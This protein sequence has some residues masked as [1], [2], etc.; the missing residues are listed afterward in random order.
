M[1]RER[2]CVRFLGS[3]RAVSPLIATV[4]LIA[5][6][7]ALGA[8]VMNWGKTYVETT[9]EQV[10]QK[11]STDINCEM[12]TDLTLKMLRGDPQICYNNGSNMIIN[13]MLEN[14]GSIDIE[15]LQ[16]TVIGNKEVFSETIQNSKII[17]GGTRKISRNYTYSEY[18]D[19]DVIEFTP[20]IKTEGSTQ[21]VLCNK[22]K[23]TIDEIYPCN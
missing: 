1:R 7:V 13:F 16:M 15:K 4:L 11:S 6:A 20:L 5:F 17:T 8:V 10:G 19:I 18:G 23:L 12:N 14:K 22:N 9:A 21:P 3:K 2:N